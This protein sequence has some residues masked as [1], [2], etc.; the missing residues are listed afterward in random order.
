[1]PP[2]GFEPTISVGERPKTYALDRAATGTGKDTSNIEITLQKCTTKPL[3]VTFDILEW[4]LRFQKYTLTFL[5][6][7]STIWC[8][9]IVFWWA[10]LVQTLLDK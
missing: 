10:K 9:Y 1:M 4:I 6:K 2:V 7:Y 8:V 5:L 3:S